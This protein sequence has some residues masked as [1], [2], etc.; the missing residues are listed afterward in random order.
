MAIASF[1][2]LCAVMFWGFRRA[3]KIRERIPPPDPE[4]SEKEKLDWVNR[5]YDEAFYKFGPLLTKIL[6]VLIAL[7]VLVSVILLIVTVTGH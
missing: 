6:L 5:Y 1:I 2:L 7:I 3:Q 4:A